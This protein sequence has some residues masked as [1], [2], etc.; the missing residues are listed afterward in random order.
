MMT[1]V[2]SICGRGDR[3]ESPMDSMFRE[4]DL[5]YWNTRFMLYDDFAGEP[6]GYK[7]NKIPPEMIKSRSFMILRNGFYG[8]EDKAFYYF[9]NGEIYKSFYY[10]PFGIPKVK[11]HKITKIAWTIARYSNI[12][13]LSWEF[14]M[15]K[16]FCKNP[17]ILDYVKYD[18]YY[19]NYADFYSIEE[20]KDDK[21]LE[22]LYRII[23]EFKA[24]VSSSEEYRVV[25]FDIWRHPLEEW[26][27]K[28]ADKH[29]K[30][31]GIAMLGQYIPMRGIKILVN[32]RHAFLGVWN[33]G[34]FIKS[35]VKDIPKYSL[36]RW[37]SD[38]SL[39]QPQGGEPMD[40]SSYFMKY[41]YPDLYRY[42]K[43][44]SETAIVTG[45]TEPDSYHFYLFPSIAQVVTV[46]AEQIASL[47]PPTHKI[48]HL[49]EIYGF[50]F[51]QRKVVIA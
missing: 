7:V 47:L 17:Y 27:E 30:D 48:E 20:I 42:V 44:D 41:L 12:F 35:D 39:L 8:Y 24:Y 32:A 51:P 9:V 10:L 23:R 14:D 31:E 13:D 29:R 28:F 36:G 19:L 16:L 46:G 1:H 34:K 50:K 26:M 2:G 4:E 43:T 5:F 3:R 37:E 49:M 40:L 38:Y 18:P 22:I 15:L 33:N 6:V 25:A 21:K 45:Y 11:V